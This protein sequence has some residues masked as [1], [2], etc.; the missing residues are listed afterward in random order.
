MKNLNN[1][2]WQV[3]MAVLSVG[4]IFSSII[5]T[6]V[7]PFLPM[8]LMNECGVTLT[9]VKL[10][11]G[12]CFSATFLISGI[13]GPIWGAIGDK[14]SL[15]MM[16]IRAALLLGVA[17]AMGGFVHTVWGFLFVRCFQGFASGL[18]PASLAILSSVVPKKRLALNIGILQSAMTVGG[19][20]GPFVGGWLAEVTS[21][22]M[23]FYIG[24]VALI[25][26]GIAYIFLVPEPKKNERAEAARRRESE[27]R[28]VEERGLNRKLVSQPLVMRMLVTTAVMQLTIYVVQ[29]IMPLYIG[30]L[31]GTMD[32]IVF[33]TGI[34]FS[35]VGVASM[36]SSPL[37]GALGSRWNYRDTLY[38]ALFTAGVFGIIQA[39]PS[40]LEGFTVWR[41]ITG[42]CFAGIAPMAVAILTAGVEQRYRGR[43]FG[44]NYAA[45]QCGNFV[46]PLLGGAMASFMPYWSVLV[47]SGVALLV[48]LA[49][50]VLTRH[51]VDTSGLDTI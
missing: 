14:H 7:V 28:P 51:N 22:R 39:V 13:M 29:P 50:L 8:Y 2:P 20:I 6:M 3:T 15:K 46:G 25:L 11:S 24:G 47:F 44:L 30:E 41:F 1:Q 37:W 48:V 31:R 38:T 32:Q 16:A 12:I 45:Q 36:I 43:L 23:S 9:D 42:F 49:W 17:Y 33:I 18:I 10:W 19:I 27:G 26:V 40:T 21:M 34:V 5:Y 4:S 35:I